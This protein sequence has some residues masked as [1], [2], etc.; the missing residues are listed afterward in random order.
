[1]DDAALFEA[2]VPVLR[3]YLDRLRALI[4]LAKTAPRPLLSE[5]LVSDGFCAGQHAA[6]AQGF[7][8]RAVFPVLGRPIPDLPSTGFQAPALLERHACVL[9]SLATIEPLDFEGASRRMVAHKAGFA[10]LQQSSSEFLTH[11]ALPNFFFHLAMVYAILRE[12]GLVIGKADF[13]G[14]HQYPQGFSFG[15]SEDI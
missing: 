4:E 9:G 3:R 14:W 13:D 10:D 2:S 1:M 15:P 11:Y 8:L 7:A 6:S 5:Q 12:N